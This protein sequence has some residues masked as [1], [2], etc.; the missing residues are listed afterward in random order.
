VL[1]IKT[2]HIIDIQH[3]K[4]IQNLALETRMSVNDII[5]K[6]EDKAE[7]KSYYELNEAA[8]NFIKDIE[9]SKGV[10]YG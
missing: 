10:I 7:S 3:S 8:K 1:K 9:S 5:E 4:R 2:I 6:M